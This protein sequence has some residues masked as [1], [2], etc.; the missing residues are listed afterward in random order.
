MTQQPIKFCPVLTAPLDNCG[1]TAVLR[2]TQ[3]KLHYRPSLFLM[4]PAIHEESGFC[5][6]LTYTLYT[7]EAIIAL[8]ELLGQAIAQDF[9]AQPQPDS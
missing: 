9:K 3:D 1:G 8:Y 6:A 4:S 2:L 7:K 5:P